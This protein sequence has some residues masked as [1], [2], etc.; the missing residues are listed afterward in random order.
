M[1]YRNHF[2]R[3]LS[4]IG[5]RSRCLQRR[6]NNKYW[7]SLSFRTATT[8]PDLNIERSDHICQIKETLQAQIQKYH[9][10]IASLSR[11]ELNAKNLLLLPI[12]HSQQYSYQSH[13]LSLLQNVSPHKHIR[14]TCVQMNQELSKFCIDM[15]MRRDVYN[16]YKIYYDEIY[17]QQEESAMDN[18]WKRL[19]HMLLRDYRRNGLGLNEKDYDKMKELSKRISELSIIFN[20]NLSLWNPKFT[21]TREQ[22]KGMDEDWLHIRYNGKESDDYKVTLQYPDYM[23]IMDKCEVESTRAKMELEFHSRCKVENSRIIEEVI[24]LR[25]MRSELLGYANHSDYICEIRMAKTSQRV[26]QFLQNLW[27]RIQDLSQRDLEVLLQLKK[28][29]KAKCG[30]TFDGEFGVEFTHIYNIYLYMYIMKL[31]LFNQFPKKNIYTYIYF[32]FFFCGLFARYYMNQ[33]VEKDCKIDNEKLREYFPL[34]LVIRG[35]FDIFQQLFGLKIVPVQGVSSKLWHEDVQAFELIDGKKETVGYFMLDLHPREGKFS[36]A[37][38]TTLQQGCSIYDHDGQRTGS[39]VPMNVMICNF[40]KPTPNKPCLLSHNE[41]TTFF[42]EFGHVMHQLCGQPNLA[43]FSGPNFLTIFFFF[44]SEDFVET[45]SQMFENWCWDK[46]SLDMMSG[47]YKDN[48]K[49]IPDELIK[50][51]Q[52][53]RKINSGLHHT[54]QLYFGML[55]QYIHS[56][57]F[58]IHQENTE[59]LCARLSES[60]WGVKATENTNFLATFSHLV[61]GY[62]ATYYGYLWSE[63]ISFDMFRTKFGKGKLLDQTVGLLFRDKVLKWGGSKDG[64]ELVT[65]FLGREPKMDAFLKEKGLE[66]EMEE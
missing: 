33:R 27:N 10:K 14:D 46:E 59:Q 65:N 24:A 38:M 29:D 13:L 66:L 35:C 6:N 40:P 20:N 57:K 56:G 17:K 31:C 49:K 18:E 63:V 54:R 28:A 41:V 26:S 47:H 61:G 1:L 11:S 36:H 60:I 3:N 9:D 43:R 53:S 50:G 64:M 15:S 44:Q 42:H 21:F 16:Q 5:S 39:Q 32:F 62:D 4:D 58:D 12:R 34:E 23:P 19:L 37:C 30:E 22:L 2:V 55:D 8:L 51:I 7:F 25:Q 48:N 52:Q 45:P